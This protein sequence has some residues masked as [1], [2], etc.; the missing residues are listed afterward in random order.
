MVKLS[1]SVSGA[2]R[3]FSFWVANGSLGYPLLKD[4]DYRSI[5]TQEPSALEMTYAI[6][7]NVLEMDNEGDVINAKAA[8]KRAAQYVLKYMTGAKVE[9]EFEDWE[10]E[11]H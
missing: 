3:Q 5:L 10:I 11:L 8:E 1:E 7:A 4:V 9:P 2:I 6:F